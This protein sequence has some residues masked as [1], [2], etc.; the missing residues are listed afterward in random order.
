MNQTDPLPGGVALLLLGIG[1]AGVTGLSLSQGDVGFA[2]SQW[3][4]LLA[5]VLA[6]PAIAL[7]VLEPGPP[8]P[9]WRSFWTVGAAAYLLHV[10]WVAFGTYN[11]NFHA[12][13]ARQGFVAITN[14]A[15]II[16][17]SLDAALAWFGPHWPNPKV[18][19]ALRFIAWAA[20]TLSFITAAPLFPTGSVKTIAISVGV[21]VIVALLLRYLRLID[22][23]PA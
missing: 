21:L 2:R 1:V 12:I 7:Y 20:V 13:L 10:W 4:A 22:W 17:W 15:V 5:L 19:R 9:W 3:S 23:K 18:R 6:A 8:G 14:V 11:G 16:L